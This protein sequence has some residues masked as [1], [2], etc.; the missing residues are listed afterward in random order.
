MLCFPALVCVSTITQCMLKTFWKLFFHQL[1][2]LHR[3]D[4]PLSVSPSAH[5][6]H[7]HTHRPFPVNLNNTVIH[8]VKSAESYLP[9][10]PPLCLQQLLQEHTQPVK[11]TNTEAVQRRHHP[12]NVHLIITAWRSG[13][14]APP[15]SS[16]EPSSSPEEDFRGTCGR[17]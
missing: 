8:L 4:P 12:L 6:K 9:A 1:C 16:P 13:Y 17:K 14:T 10:D 2:L 15:E 3:P 11:E 7:T 5:L